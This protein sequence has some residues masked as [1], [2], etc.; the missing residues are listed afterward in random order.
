MPS[1][2][3]SQFA[4]EGVVVAAF[5]KFFDDMPA[6]HQKRWQISYDDELARGGSDVDAAIAAWEDLGLDMLP[7]PSGVVR[8]A[9]LR[10]TTIKSED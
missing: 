9:E 1:K 2:Q 8:I 10:G 3:P 7:H 6:R 4:R 5:T